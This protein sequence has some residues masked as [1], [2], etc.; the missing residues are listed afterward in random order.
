MIDQVLSLAALCVMGLAAFGLGRP[1]V[2]GL[3]PEERDPLSV[4]VWSLAVG[5]IGMGWLL[6][7]LGMVGLLYAP[8]IGVMTMTAC[9]WGIGE[10]IRARQA[11]GSDETSAKDDPE[12]TPWAAPASWLSRAI[13]AAAAVACFGSLVGAMA[14]P[15]AGDAMCYHLELPK[16]FLLEHRLLYLPYH[17]N[18]TF[19]L[20]T[21]M[22]YLW[23]LAIRGPVCAQLVHWALGGLLAL[24]TVLLARPILG[25]RWSWIAGA[26]V[27]LTP[28]INNQMTA[29]LND[30]A[31]AA[32]TTLAVAAWWRAQVNEEGRRWFVLAGL[33]AGGALGTKY[34]AL[35]FAVA[36]AVAWLAAWI[37]RPQQRR[38]LLQ[39]ATIAAVVAISVAGP[40]YLRAAWHRGNPFFPFLSEAFHRADAVADGRGTLPSSKSPLGRTPKGLAMAP[41]QITMQP[42]RFGGRGHQLGIL[43]L[44]AV[45]GLFFTRRLRGLGMLLTIAGTYGLLWYLLR[46]NVRFLFPIVPLLSVAVVWV[47]ME[48]R[49]FP[50]PARWLT[51][52]TFG[53]IL[54]AMALVPLHR[55]Y[56]SLAVAV[57]WETREDY[58]LRHE[59]TYEAAA[60]A[61]DMLGPEAHLLS[62]DYRAFYFDHRVTRENIYRRY[63]HFDEEITEPSDF[64]RQLRCRGFTHLLLT[65]KLA[66]DGPPCD[67]TLSRLAEAQWAGD[68]AD[69]LLKLTDYR[70][71]DVEG[72][73]WRYRLVML[74]SGRQ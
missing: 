50:P 44:A 18:A 15:T 7:G 54:A 35:L 51:G 47:W 14:P 49:R 3:V 41:W 38:A 58:L 21:E 29:P 28:G 43:M 65:E 67:S 46:Q 61:N 25:P 26:V 13:L 31:L 24:G 22:W 23:A 6:L 55:S 37:R 17:D 60:V 10:L 66:G 16:R 27:L 71:E 9:F 52:V 33:A 40:W 5:L 2:R 20:L 62:Q 72:N 48:M 68:R 11:A 36:M 45:P 69:E 8:L 1:L 59:P 57:G 19:P 32:M 4:A 12:Q 56:G 63:T 64:S 53:V 39:G 74:G 73:Q 34:L 70:F 42:E 30:V